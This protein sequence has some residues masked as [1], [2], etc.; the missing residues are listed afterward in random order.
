VFAGSENFSD[1]LLNHNRELGLIISDA[2]VLSGIEQAFN[3][4]FGQSS[5]GSVTVTNPSSQTGTV[6]T[7][8]SLQI[9]ASDTAG[10]T[11]SY[12]ATGLSINDLVRDGW[13]G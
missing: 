9:Q 1:N 13:G 7:A 5:T 2:G 8:G 4:D 12:S 11:L 6:G 3:A 10:G